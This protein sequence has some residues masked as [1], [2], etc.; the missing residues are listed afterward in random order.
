M[1]HVLWDLQGTQIKEL[2]NLKVAN[3]VLQNDGDLSKKEYENFI[4]DLVNFLV[5][6]GEPH[7]NTRK[8][9][10]Y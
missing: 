6:V 4:K 5:Y 2:S 9:L 10:V 8:N 3:L 7:Q 1:P